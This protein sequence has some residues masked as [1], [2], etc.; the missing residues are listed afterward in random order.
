MKLILKLSAILLFISSSFAQN[1]SNEGWTTITPNS[2]TKIVY[3]SSTSGNDATAEIYQASSSIIGV[4]PFLPSASVKA[5]KTVEAVKKK[6][7]SGEATWVLFKRGDVFTEKLFRISGKSKENPFVYASYGP[8]KEMPLFHINK[9]I[10]FSNNGR[11]L[12]H[13]YLIGLSFYAPIHN[14]NDPAFAG[15]KEFGPKGLNL[16]CTSGNCEVRDVLIEG[17]IFRFFSGSSIQAQKEGVVE[18]IR[19]RRNIILDTYANK[20]HSQGLY[21]ASVDGFLLEE[22]IFDHNGWYQQSMTYNDQKDGQATIFNHNTYFGNTKNVIFRENSFYRSSS[23]GTKWTANEGIASSSGIEITNNLYHDFEVGISLGGNVTKEP[24]RFKDIIVRGNV[25]NS[26]GLSRPTNRTLGWNIS[27]HD[28]DNGVCEDNYIVHQNSDKVDNGNGIMITGENRNLTIKNN[29]LYNLK[30]TRYIYFHKTYDI[31]STVFEGNELFTIDNKSKHV[32]IRGAFPSSEFQLENNKYI[33]GNT[34]F[35]VNRKK[36]TLNEWENIASEDISNS[37]KAIDYKDPTRSLEKYVKEVLRLSSLDDFYVN[38]RKQNIFNWRE[39]Y[40]ARAINKWIKA[41]YENKST[42]PVVDAEAPTAPE[43]LVASEVTATSLRLV[44]EKSSDNIGVTGY[45]LINVDTNLPVSTSLITNENYLVSDLKEGVTYNFAIK[46]VDAIGNESVLSDIITVTTN[47]KPVAA[48]KANVQTGTVPL[49]ISFN[50]EDSSD[51]DSGDTISK[52]EWNFGDGS[53]ISSESKPTH[54]F[55]KTGEY[56]VTLKVKDS[57]GAYSEVVTMSVK[58]EEDAKEENPSAST[59]Y[60]GE[61]RTSQGGTRNRSDISG[62]TGTAFVDFGGKDSYIEWD[63][64][65]VSEDKKVNF[66]FRY[67]NGSSE[68]RSCELFIDDVSYGVLDF[69]TVASGDWK[70]WGVNEKTITL[71]QGVYKV[72]LVVSSDNGG[73]NFDKMEVLLASDEEE[74]EEEEEEEDTTEG[75]STGGDNGSGSGSGSENGDGDGEGDNNSSDPKEADHKILLDTELASCESED[76]D[77]PVD[78]KSLRPIGINISGIADYSTEFSFTDAFKQSRKWIP[79]N[80]DGTGGWTSN[81]EVPLNEKGFPSQIPYDNGVDTPQK[82]RTLLLWSL[83]ENTFPEGN[84]RLIVKGK[85]KIRLSG[86]ARG[87]YETPIDTEVYANDGVILQIESS[88]VNNPISDIKFILPEYTKNYKTKT[89]T[90]EFVSFLADFQ[91]IRFMDWLK[92]NN[93]NVAKWSDR[94]RKNNYTQSL[95]NGVAWEYVIELS[96]LLKKDLWINIPHKADDD[97]IKQLAILLEKEVN[98]N[99]KIYLEYSNEIWNAGFK[100]HREAAAL[101]EALGYSGRTWE[102]AAKY[103]AKRCADIFRIFEENFSN[104]SRF[105]KIVSSQAANSGLSGR[106]LEFFNDP[107]YNP[108]KVTADALSIAPYFAGTSISKHIMENNL[109]ETITI[110]E[111]VDLMEESL[112]KADKW[113]MNNSKVADKFGLD[114]LA[115]EGGQHLVAIGKDVNNSLLTEKLNEAN[116]HP[117]LKQVYCQYFDNWYKNYG[118]LF[119]H[120]ASHNKY[121]K[122]GSWGVK[123]HFKDV[124]NPKYLALKECVFNEEH[125]ASKVTTS[126]EVLKNDLKNSFIIWPNPTNGGTIHLQLKE[127]IEEEVT[128]AVYGMSGNLVFTETKSNLEKLYAINLK[129]L[130]RG[131]YVIKVVSAK[132]S[133]ESRLIIK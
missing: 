62:F 5:F 96:N 131:V 120:F 60:Q 108:T 32:E 75:G 14:P 106:I 99:L 104:D 30:N 91:T 107:V 53:A 77:V 54:T 33:G 87:E 130:F 81:I 112:P 76:P 29:K 133:L 58:V 121:T 100:Q 20:G 86:G 73:P 88:D 36:L 68:N 70:K 9:S 17:C 119:M 28:W 2:T 59:V 103:N 13:V 22:N 25:L 16:L 72:K 127:S 65:V 57:R 52:Y 44:W 97:Y 67:A 35:S 83:P 51:P 89:F 50:G 27:I 4:D 113:M 111:I 38:L 101:G 82:L 126:N 40:T 115:Y 61:D 122:H 105:V 71:N 84:F 12:K 74:E 1:I 109:L 10:A 39:E 123:E 41:G 18:N 102:K 79:F 21:S 110:P 15:F 8:K 43:N 132:Q 129:G 92:T 42:S 49:V 95:K 55:T 80:A 26:A 34:S 3:V 46:A 63:N 47:S 124:N 31:K 66:I 116:R 24:Y 56:Q 48:I 90:N 19:L 78:G 37:T 23:I 128:I 85:G 125:I 98:P 94:N 114:L 69:S 93:S 64:V 11:T 118:G 117:D 7:K 6:V 45:Q